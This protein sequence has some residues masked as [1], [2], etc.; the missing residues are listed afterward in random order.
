MAVTV[1]SIEVVETKIIQADFRLTNFRLIWFRVDEF[2]PDLVQGCA[3]RLHVIVVRT[4]CS[5][6]VTRWICSLVGILG[7]ACLID[8]WIS[9]PE[10]KEMHD[11]HQA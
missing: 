2:P 10:K 8:Y 11:K 9:E 5:F 3:K 1:T 7:M 6:S 4:D